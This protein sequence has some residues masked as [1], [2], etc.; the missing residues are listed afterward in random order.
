MYSGVSTGSKRSEDR[1]CK[2]NGVVH[3]IDRRKR[4]FG[5]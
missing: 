5:I 3:I 2:A 1:M 4:S